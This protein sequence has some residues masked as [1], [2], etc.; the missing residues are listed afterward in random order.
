MGKPFAH[1]KTP[2]SIKEKMSEMP[3]PNILPKIGATSLFNSSGITVGSYNK[4]GN[5]SGKWVN[6]RGGW[7]TAGVTSRL[8][9]DTSGRNSVKSQLWYSTYLLGTSPLTTPVS[10]INGDPTRVIPSVPMVMPYNPAI[11]IGYNIADTMIIGNKPNLW[12]VQYAITKGLEEINRI[13]MAASGIKYTQGLSSSDS[14]NSSG[15]ILVSMSNSILPGSGTLA[16]TLINNLSGGKNSKYSYWQSDVYSGGNNRY[17]DYYNI[18]Y[19]KLDE[20]SGE[21]QTT[22]NSKIINYWIKPLGYIN[23]EKTLD[24]KTKIA[25]NIVSYLEKRTNEIN[26]NNP[27]EVISEE[28]RLGFTYEVI[29]PNSSDPREQLKKYVRDEINMLDVG[30]DYKNYKDY[31]KFMFEDISDSDSPGVPIIFRATLTGLTD[32]PNP[33][34][35]STEYVGNAQKTYI[36]K[37]WERKIGFSFKVYV[38]SKQELKT[39]WN[40]LNYLYGLAYPIKYS[41]QTSIISPIVRLTIG[42][43]YDGMVGHFDNLEYSFEDDTPWDLEEGSQLPMGVSINIG[44]TVMHEGYDI[45]TTQTPHFKYVASSGE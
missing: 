45:S 2:Q 37:G 26:N 5:I 27:K 29:N 4:G 24:R 22:Y 40:K 30:E 41:S 8:L 25:N 15:N 32:S 19:N 31:I 11:D 21:S 7:Y 38:T 28:D 9:L 35:N 18:S 13:Q 3:T 6:E 10:N 39:T 33:S 12:N 14:S 20:V 36:Y 17:S 16:N 34:W 1:M 42:D 23:S 43:L 44:F